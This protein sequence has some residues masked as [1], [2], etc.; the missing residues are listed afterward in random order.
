MREASTE[1]CIQ[2]YIY[3][4]I[5]NGCYSSVI[6]FMVYLTTLSTSDCVGSNNYWKGYGRKRLWPIWSIIQTCGWSKWGTTREPSVR[7]A[8]LIQINSSN[9]DALLLAFF[10]SVNKWFRHAGYL[11]R[12][13]ARN[14]GS[15]YFLS[16]SEWKM[17]I[18]QERVDAIG[19]LV[20]QIRV[21]YRKGTQ[22]HQ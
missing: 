6:L 19:W 12:P 15:P 13:N 2:I 18:S 11:S 16:C 22:S 9:T 21:E 7:I 4:W 10:P 1:A 20:V 17:E 3:R 14:K 5:I 8:S